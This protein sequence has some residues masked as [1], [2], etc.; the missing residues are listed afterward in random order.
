[1]VGLELKS[2]VLPNSSSEA[3]AVGC[4]FSVSDLSVPVPI[5]WSIAFM[6]GEVT[7]PEEMIP[8]LP[9]FPV[10]LFGG[11]GFLCGDIG[12]GGIGL[13]GTG[14]RRVPGIVAGLLGACEGTVIFFPVLDGLGP[15]LVPAPIPFPLDIPLDLVLPGLV[16]VLFRPGLAYGLSC[17][18]GLTGIVCNLCG[19]RVVFASS[20]VRGILVVKSSWVDWSV[21][22]RAVCSSSRL[23][24]GEITGMWGMPRVSKGAFV[25]SGGSTLKVTGGRTV[26]L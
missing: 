21:S 19:A 6:G 23:G 2:V 8:A 26:S 20:V 24:L 10:T 3:G 1:M 12:L 18:L 25:V 14:G 17:I 22:S 11:K 7:R 15:C 13:G 16:V 9:G 5:G 4:L